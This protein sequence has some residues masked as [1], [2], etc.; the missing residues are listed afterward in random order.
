ML[1]NKGNLSS[2]ALTVVVAL[3]MLFVGL[4][5]IN[6]VADIQPESDLYDYAYTTTTNTTSQVANTTQTAPYSFDIDMVTIEDETPIK[7]ITIYFENKSADVTANATLNGVSLGTWSVNGVTEKT[8]SNVNF[9]DDAT[10]NITIGSDAS[11]ANSNVINVTV[12]YPSSKTSTD[13]GTIFSNLTTNTGTIFDV[14]ILVIIIVALGV[15]IAVLRGFG[16]TRQVSG[17]I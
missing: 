15:A 1:R 8:F 11:D 13:F 4:Y 14:M 3:V 7:T 17:K 10:N 12:K 6:M 9:V 5:A 2:L 16:S